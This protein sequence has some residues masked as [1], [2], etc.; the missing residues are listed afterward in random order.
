MMLTRCTFALA[1][2]FISGCTFGVDAVEIRAEDSLDSAG[3]TLFREDLS[4]VAE[5]RVT[6][7]GGSQIRAALVTRGL[8]GPGEAE[9]AR[10]SFSVDLYTEGSV[11]GVRT[12]SEGRYAELLR[13]AGL[14]LDVPAALDVAFELG[15]TSAHVTDVGGLLQIDGDSGSVVLRGTDDIEVELR[16]GSIVADAR[17]AWLR[18]DSGSMELEV[19][20]RVDAA[21]R[22]G[23]IELTL[24]GGGEVRTDTGSSHIRVLA[25]HEDLTV[26]AGNGSV[27]IELA[28]GVGAAL[29]LDAGNGSVRVGLPTGDRDGESF[30]G[31]VNGGGPTLHVRTGNGSIAVDV[32]DGG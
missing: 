8:V 4:H 25:L 26:S 30:I 15:S 23:S 11:A 10:E 28:A 3:I 18:T 17:V 32:S 31:T 27:K 6:G 2:F 9:A 1:L 21:A 12:M 29:D 5:L 20:E 13:P 14:E 22:S 19:T 24:A 7:E 16:S